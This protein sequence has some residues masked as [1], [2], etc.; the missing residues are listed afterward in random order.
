MKKTAVL[1]QREPCETMLSRSSGAGLERPKC[2]EDEEIK[3][4]TKNSIPQPNDDDEADTQ[5]WLE[6]EINDV[7]CDV[8]VTMCRFTSGCGLDMPLPPPPSCVVTEEMPCPVEPPTESELLVASNILF[9][10]M[11]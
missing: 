6:E 5:M 9:L 8:P 2:I 4:A 11:K 3:V 7:L 10:P 1:Y